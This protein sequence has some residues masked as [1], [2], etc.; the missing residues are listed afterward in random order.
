M[1]KVK[2]IVDNAY[3]LLNGENNDT[4]SGDFDTLLAQMNQLIQYWALE[5]DW[6]SLLDPFYTNSDL[7]ISDNTETVAVPRG[8]RLAKIKGVKVYIKDDYGNVIKSFD[9]TR[10]STLLKNP[11]T[12]LCAVIG[13]KIHFNDDISKYQGNTLYLPMIFLPKVYKD[14][15]EEVTIDNPAWLETAMAYNLASVSPVPFIARN[16]DS[17]KAEMDRLMALMKENNRKSGHLEKHPLG[18][19]DNLGGY[20]GEGYNALRRLGR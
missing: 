14:P 9:I 3:I 8:G 19:N 11:S 20:M 2:Q 5:A 6:D 16:K 17:L 1:S 4:D 12:S 18:G 10:A 15:N 13:G 7:V